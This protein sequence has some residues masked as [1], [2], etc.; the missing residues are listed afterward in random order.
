MNEGK[1]QLLSGA[2]SK[3]RCSRP[4][5]VTEGSKK[6][7]LIRYPMSAIEVALLLDCICSE[8]PESA[9]SAEP[10]AATRPALTCRSLPGRAL[11]CSFARPAIRPPCSIVGVGRSSERTIRTPQYFCSMAVIRWRGQTSVRMLVLNRPGFTGGWFVQCQATL[12]SVF[13]FA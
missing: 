2:S 12:S 8:G 10:T 7:E 5:I 11:R 13:R 1:P 4:V 3:L 9:L 6:C